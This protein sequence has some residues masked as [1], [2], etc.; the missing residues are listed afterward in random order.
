VSGE[1]SKGIG[2]KMGKG[3]RRAKKVQGKNRTSDYGGQRRTRLKEKEAKGNIH[4]TDSVAAKR[5]QS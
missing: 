3:R 2:E 4:S 5:R 1:T